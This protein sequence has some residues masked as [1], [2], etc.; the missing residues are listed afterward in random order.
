VERA[1]PPNLGMPVVDNY[2]GI[3][4]GDVDRSKKADDFT[5][6]ISEE[7]QSAA[8]RSTDEI[9]MRMI[10]IT[11]ELAEIWLSK[12]INTRNRKVQKNHVKG[13]ARDIVSDRWMVNAQPI[14]FTADPFDPSAKGHLRL[15]N[16]QHRLYAVLEAGI[17]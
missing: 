12:Q 10:T 3:R 13:I 2:P 16:G 8:Q 6:Q 14:S 15:L 9:S 1:A 5:G 4:E 11:P 7:V 17:P